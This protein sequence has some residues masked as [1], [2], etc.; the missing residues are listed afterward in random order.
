MTRR[1]DNAK[2]SDWKALITEQDDFLRPLVE[3]VVQQV[4]KAEQERG[5]GHREERA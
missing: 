1:Q 3:E 4:L 5:A 2:K